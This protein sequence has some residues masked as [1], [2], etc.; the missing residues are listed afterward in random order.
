MCVLV[1]DKTKNEI[2]E[3]HLD[4]E[5][6]MM[7][8]DKVI[9]EEM[10]EEDVDIEKL[11]SSNIGFDEKVFTS[12]GISVPSD[13]NMFEDDKQKNDV[14]TDNPPS[15]ISQPSEITSDSIEEDKVCNIK[16]EFFNCI[17]N[18]DF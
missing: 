14:E 6:R 1:L 12:D 16:K 10:L 8:A 18:A 15:T 7:K 5:H 2:T 4:I 3:E 11:I 17:Q 13:I 9:P